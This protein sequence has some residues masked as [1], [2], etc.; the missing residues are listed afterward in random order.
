MGASGTGMHTAIDKRWSRLTFLVSLMIAGSA[1]GPAN[2]C[3]DALSSLV[4]VALKPVLENADVCRELKQKVSTPLGPV[5]IGVDKTER[6]ELR[7]L[8]YCPGPAEST[9]DGTVFVQCKTSDAATI[10]GSAS[11]TFDIAMRI[12]NSTCE[13]LDLK[14]TPRGEIGRLFAGAAGLNGQL[15]KEAARHI[16]KLCAGGR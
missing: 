2:A 5:T 12:Q 15:K 1:A 10:K 7:K 9:L 6:V 11:E 16:R 13:I 3:S 4:A 14:V 8:Q